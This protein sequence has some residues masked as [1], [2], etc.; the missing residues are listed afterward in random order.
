[1]APL[2]HQVPEVIF[3]GRLTIAI[4]QATVIAS[5]HATYM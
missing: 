4:V 1:M 3:S 2:T 5:D